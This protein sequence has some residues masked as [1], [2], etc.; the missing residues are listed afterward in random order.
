MSQSTSLTQH[1]LSLPL[2]T[3]AATQHHFLH[4]AGTHTLPPARLALWLAQDR[5]YAAHAYPRFVGH[6]IARIPYSSAHAPGSP[7]EQRHREV[8]RV[9]VYSLQNVVR[10]VAFF[11][12]LGAQWGL[13]VDAW[14]E[15]KETRD[16]TAEMARVGA[17]G[18]L[19]DGLVFLWAMEKL[20]L[21]S[22]RYVRS[23]R[24]IASQ[25]LTSAASDAIDSFADNWTNEEFEK[26]VQDIAN[27]VDDWIK[28]GTPAWARAEAVWARV[29]E[30]EEAF[31][32][33]AGDEERLDLRAAAT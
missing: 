29:I 27:L 4:A 6:L 2:S 11:D 12:E 26:F 24:S 14:R 1:L 13:A 33:N 32:P 22:W 31:W 18:T 23:L 3:K 30:L 15:R 16:Y 20:Y 28:P 17:E 9:L 19:E 5:I 8:L 7:A 25:A 21:D 10:E